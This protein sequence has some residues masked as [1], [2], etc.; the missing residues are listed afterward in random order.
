M[1]LG[2]NDRTKKLELA[3]VKGMLGFY[4]LF[5]KSFPPMQSPSSVDDYP[6][7]TDYGSTAWIIA[8]RSRCAE[9]MPA[10]G[11]HMQH[12]RRVTLYASTVQCSQSPLTRRRCYR[13][14]AGSLN[15]E[16]GLNSLARDSKTTSRPYI[17]VMS[18]SVALTSNQR[19]YPGVAF[20]W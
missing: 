3:E 17:Y 7:L 6:R 19:S 8:T 11:S 15:P 4:L 5:G 9:N 14:D 2:M 1:I 16:R 10:K 18:S 13:G 12:P 20:S